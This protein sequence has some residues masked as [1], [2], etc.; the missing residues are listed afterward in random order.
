MATEHDKLVRDRIPELIRADDQRPVTH[1]ADDEEFDRRLRAKLVEEATEIHESG[2][3][4]ELAD[5]KAVLDA[6]CAHSGV[7]D[8]EL[9]ELVA[10]K[11]DR[12]GGFEDRVVLERVEE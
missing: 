8:E 4:A 11:A 5:V 6:L 9:A 1:T 12:R 10:D 3:T 7:S 2:R